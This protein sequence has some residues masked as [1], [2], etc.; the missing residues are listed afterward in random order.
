MGLGLLDWKCHSS[1]TLQKV[2][3]SSFRKLLQSVFLFLF[4]KYSLKHRTFFLEILCHKTTLWVEHSWIMPWW[5]VYK[6]SVCSLLHTPYKYLHVHSWKM[7]LS[8]FQDRWWW[9]LHT[10]SSA[11]STKAWKCVKTVS[12]LFALWNKVEV[13]VDKCIEK[14]LFTIRYFSRPLTFK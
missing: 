6:T 9:I 5:K 14:L 10:L 13:I 3:Y 7:Q 4:Q 8:I 11:K 2:W 1:F 12:F